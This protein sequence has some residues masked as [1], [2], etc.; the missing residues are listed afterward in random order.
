[1]VKFLDL[2]AINA[3]YKQEIINAMTAV[4]DSGCYIGGESVS[5]FEREFATFCDTKYAVGVGNG[6]DALALTL[7][8]WRE[9]GLIKDG[10]EILVPGNTFIATILAI[11]GQGLKPVFVEPDVG[12]HNI[13]V[14][15]M[16]E[17]LS[18]KTRA[19]I[20]VHLYG[21]MC[22]MPEITKFAVQ[23]NLLVLE[24]CAQAHGAMVGNRSAGSWG[25]AGA[26]SFYPGKNLGA[27]GDA[28]IITTND[29]DL[30]QV[31]RKMGN[32]GFSER[33]YS[34]VQGVNSRLDS[35]QAAILSVKLKYLRSDIE[36]R[37]QIAHIYSTNISN[38]LIT[39]PLL[40][41][42]NEHVWHLFVILT[43]HRDLLQLFLSERGI[44]SLIH[45]PIPPHKQEA[46]IEFRGIELPVTETLSS[47]VLSLPI[48]PTMR[49]E[50][51][52]RV[53]DV[54]NS[55]SPNV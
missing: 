10:D 54:I 53:C 4:F 7:K 2:L 36:R 25:D 20:P 51:V 50:D 9:L 5:S 15:N 48:D 21:R 38:Q 41:N 23:Y 47:M 34:K 52:F 13:S 31:L 11:T 28:G 45:Y 3:R 40:G 44:E 46:F 49:D 37:R 29:G 39:L 14:K 26:F 43:K 6:L 32:Y 17:L 30:E 55:F 22:P 1:M 12:S 33:Y 42:S 24:D 35:I 19:I 8:C 18:T 16:F 27:I